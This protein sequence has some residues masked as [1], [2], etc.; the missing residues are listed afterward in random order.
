MAVFFGE[1]DK[2]VSRMKDYEL[3][4]YYQNLPSDMNPQHIAY[5]ENLMLDRDLDCFTHYH[6][7]HDLN[8]PDVKSMID[9]FM[10]CDE[11]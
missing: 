4:N 11:F 9:R 8:D 6:E 3:V 2:I 7:K 5:V 1:T 10:I